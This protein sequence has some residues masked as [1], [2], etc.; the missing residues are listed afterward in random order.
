MIITSEQVRNISSEYEARTIY[1]EV[2]LNKA[3]I[4]LT[5]L[6]IFGDDNRIARNALWVLTKA[7][8]E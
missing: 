1:H 6:F 5:N 2:K 4:E 7:N 8:T 3:I